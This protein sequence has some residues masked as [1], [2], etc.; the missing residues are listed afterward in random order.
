MG[1]RNMAWNEWVELD[2]NFV[3][4]H[5]LRE[6]R[7]RH[8]GERV[9]K[10]N[11]PQPGVVAGGHD[12]GARTLVRVSMLCKRSLYVSAARELVYELAEYL[13]RRYPDVYHVTR[14]MAGEKGAY[15][16]YGEGQIQSIKVVPL[17]RTY[18]IEK[19]EPMA[20]SALL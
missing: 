2:Q 12:A 13:S 20:L 6:H 14:K 4:H 10:V 1:I 19:E 18:D 11:E 15:S 7:I 16:W 17:Q 9:V 3:A 8:R 5:R